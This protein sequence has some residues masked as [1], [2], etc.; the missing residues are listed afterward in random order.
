MTIKIGDYTFNGPYEDPS[1][2]SSKS[3]VYAIHCEKDSKY[4]LIDVG[5]SGDVKDRV[6]KHDR[7]DC[8]KKECSTTLTYSEYLTP[9][10]QQAGRKKI[11]QAIRAK[12]NPPCGKE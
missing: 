2:L 3:G 10:L 1:K 4:F 7:K 5:E 8:W 12:F 11:E 6:E 9:N